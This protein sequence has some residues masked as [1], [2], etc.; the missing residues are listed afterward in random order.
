MINVK[1]V[2]EAFYECEKLAKG[3]VFIY[4]AGDAMP[5]ENTFVKSHYNANINNESRTFHP[6]KKR[7]F[8]LKYKKTKPVLFQ[9]QK[10]DVISLRHPIPVNIFYRYDHT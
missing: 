1:N 5:V 10:F 3:D 6:Y 7:F 4:T 8:T 2:G 9:G